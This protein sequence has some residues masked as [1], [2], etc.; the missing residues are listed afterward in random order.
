MVARR[1]RLAILSLVLTLTATSAGLLVGVALGSGDDAVRRSPTPLPGFTQAVFLSHLND[2][3]RIPVFP[4][5]P[6]FSLRSFFTIPDDGFTLQYVKEG[7]HTGTH[8]STPCHFHVGAACAGQMNAGDFILP[9]VVIDV[10]AAVEADVDHEVTVADLRAWEADN[11]QSPSAPRSCCGPAAT[12]SGV[13][14][15]PPTAPRTTTG[16][17]AAGRFRQPGF[18]RAAVRW[19]IRTGVLA[20]RGALGTD[21]FGPDP[22]SDWAPT[23]E[24]FLTL[25]KHRFT[26]ENLTNLGAMPATGAWIVI[27]G[28]ATDT[29]PARPPRCSDWCRSPAS[30]D[31]PGGYIRPEEDVR[32]RGYEPNKKDLQD[33]LRR[34][35]G[36]VRGLQRMIQ[37]DTYCIDVLTQVNSVNAAL[38]AVAMELLED[39]VRHC[40][41]ESIRRGSG[42]EKVEELMAAV[43][44]LAGK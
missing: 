18:S 2:P 15:S 30:A 14:R 6:P 11:G 13:P 27:G 43:V 24:T 20:D 7:E 9:A 23:L 22:G 26:L 41:R 44:R 17:S 38:R 3:A 1:R 16:G 21:T 4:G 35:E 28:R 32:M 42:D 36:Q 31:T 8:Y 29:G 40:V 5:D 34:I 37:E 19:L 25:R 10:R 33:R 12:G 39:H